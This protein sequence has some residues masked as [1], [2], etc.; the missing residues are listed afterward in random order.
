MSCWTS[1]LPDIFRQLLL[2]F[3][4]KT[5]F[6][7]ISQKP[8][9]KEIKIFIK[10]RRDVKFFYILLFFLY[11]LKR[12]FKSG[13]RSIVKKISY[14]HPDSPYALMKFQNDLLHYL[15]IKHKKNQP[16]VIVCIGTDRATGDCLGPLVGQALLPSPQYSVFG[17]LKEPIHAKNLN[18]TF[19]EIY[20]V[21]QNPFIIAV[22]SCLGYAQHVG[23]IT[24]SPLPLLPGRGV[25][26]QLPPIGQL[27]ITG[28]VNVFSDSVSNES[29]I[30]NTR[31][32]TV[33]KL[34]DFITNG[35]KSANIPSI[36][37]VSCPHP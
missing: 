12:E 29:V 15:K 35:I 24:L 34:A 14:Y 30:Q 6:S 13:G 22:D 8:Y 17:T 37:Q 7:S 11:T 16:L 32:H 25:S 27:S 2:C 36:Y 18:Q 19:K 5:S 4:E 31:L 20:S 33:I 9:H 3:H 23:C 26:K 10:Q 1:N 28:I 21:C